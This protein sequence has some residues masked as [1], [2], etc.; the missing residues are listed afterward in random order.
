MSLACQQSKAPK[1]AKIP[2]E[3]LKTN[4]DVFRGSYSFPFHFEI[5]ILLSRYST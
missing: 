2:L 5:E 4:D 1:A 3:F